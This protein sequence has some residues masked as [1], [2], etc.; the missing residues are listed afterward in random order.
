ML[1]RLGTAVFVAG[2]LAMPAAAA[3]IVGGPGEE[4]GLRQAEAGAVVS[5]PRPM[6]S[7]YVEAG[8]HRSNLTT[9][10]SDWTGE[11]AKAV[12]QGGGA[13]WYGE[14]SNQR[15][16]VDHGVFGSIGATRVFDEDWYA[17]LFA[18]S[19][20]GGF[21]LPRYR[22]DGF[23]NRKWM[24]RRNLVTTLGLGYYKAKDE[25]RDR[26]L[27]ASATWYFQ[28]PWIVE[29]GARFNQSDPGSVH[30]TR[31]YF[32]I[33]QGRDQAHYLTLRHEAGKEAYQLVGPQ[34]VLS[35]FSSRATSLTWRQW[36][37]GNAG[38]NLRAERYV[39]PSYSRNSVELGFFWAL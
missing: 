37:V 30:A 20:S 18:G 12:V 15:R 7:G 8:L 38:L 31:G 26:S 35:D 34:A 13:T 17:S 4:D 10:N 16:F 14:L 21:F 33:T 25:H 1:T 28:A 9:G 6:Q 29:G 2:L 32:A 24:Q 39:N 3:Q 36:L 27:F 5:P 11:Y 19:S 23:I 22:I